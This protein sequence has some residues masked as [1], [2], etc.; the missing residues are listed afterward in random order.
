M[1]QDTLARQMA[2]RRVILKPAI[3]VKTVVFVHRAWFAQKTIVARKA[4]RKSVAVFVVLF[5]TIVSIRL[6][7][8]NAS[9]RTQ[10][11]AAILGVNQMNTAP[12]QQ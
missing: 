2:H 11:H 1:L 5:T 12:S 7:A 4:S 10:N 9:R 6:T 8:R 3:I